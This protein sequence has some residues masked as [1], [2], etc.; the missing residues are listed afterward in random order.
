MARRAVAKKHQASE[1]PP[2]SRIA[3]GGQLAGAQQDFGVKIVADKLHLLCVTAA[4]LRS[5]L[6]RFL[7]TMVPK[8][9]FQ[10]YQTA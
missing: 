5:Q 2:A 4:V 8:D 3:N 9:P 10:T 6:Q 7:S 1:T